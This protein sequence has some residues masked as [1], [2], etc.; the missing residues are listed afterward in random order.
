MKIAV[1]VPNWIGDAVLS[2]P[3][4]AAL[5][6][7]HPKAEIQV[8]AR[9]WVKDLF[10]FGTPADGVISL[11]NDTSLSRLHS[12]ARRIRQE[13]F[14]AG[15]LL[16]NSFGTALVFALARVPERWGYRRDG[17]GFLLTRGVPYDDTAPPVHQAEYYLRLL[18]GLGIKT[19]P[20]PIRL[21]LAPEERKA[22]RKLLDSL[23]LKPVKKKP[24]IFLNPGAS[25]GP[26]KRWPVERF[27]RLAS[28]LQAA[29]S[30]RIVITGSPEEAGLA[31]L[32]A[33]S[34]PRRPIVLSGRTSLRGL[35]GILSWADLFITNDSGPM[36]MANALGVPVVGLFGPTNPAVTRPYQPPST[37]IW[38]GAAC[39]PCLYRSCPYGHQ[40]LTAIEPEEVLEAALSYLR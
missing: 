16:T 6:A 18:R 31:E 5:K 8:V 36:H 40:C 26:A 14:D 30:A 28:R 39:W 12:S 1:R 19:P 27:A 4:L 7:R 20:A 23:G 10:T 32:L 9:D 33:S 15:L 3:A 38:K 35:L 17:R 21:S 37:V 34:L 29:R 24:L 13:G 22:A 11:S 2:L 25:Y